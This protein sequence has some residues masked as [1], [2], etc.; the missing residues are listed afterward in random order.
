MKPN[1]E[2]ERYACYSST[3]IQFYW[4]ESEP[5]ASSHLSYDFWREN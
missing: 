3:Q 1:N 4:Y 5:Q 2:V